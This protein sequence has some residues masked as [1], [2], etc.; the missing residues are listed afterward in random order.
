MNYLFKNAKMVNEQGELQSIEMLVKD[1]IIQ[2]I[3]ETVEAEN[4]E[5][6]DVEGKLL[7]PGFIDVHVHLREPGGE[8]KETIATGSLAAA[9]GGFTTICAM[10][11]TRPV[12][13]S[14]EHMEALQKRIEETAHVNVLPYASI[15]VRQAGAELTDFET[16]KKL[17]AF[18]LT[19]DGVG[20]QSAAMMLEA[21]KRAAKL[22]MTIVAHCEENTLINKGSVHEGEFSKKNDLNGIPS[23][24]ESVH[25]ARDVLL[26]EAANCHY[27]VCHISTKESVRVVRDAK[28]AGIR[29]TAEVSPHHLILCDEDIPGLDTN[30]K[31]NPPLRGSDDR[32]ALIEGLLDGTIDM[33]AT[34]HAP[35]AADEKAMGMQRA[36]FGIVGLET[37]FPLLYTHFVEKGLLSLQQ[38]LDFMAK[39]PADVFGLESGTLKTGAKAD[40]TIIDLEQENV[41]DPSTFISKGKNTPF[42]GWQCKGWPIKTFVNG[43]LVWEKGSVLA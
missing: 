21:M 29:V 37:A 39:K 41:I 19:D 14:A 26:A 11:N 30:F 16:L 20:V 35:H 2:E 32:K 15:T 1:G 27:H 17:G 5:I 28:R 22:D 4:V 10:P 43:K 24:C 33:I 42:A 7:S 3:A 8:H 40:I 31:M 34:D 6:I 38:L 25:I 13:D 9:K 12:P 23:V 36:P 18:A